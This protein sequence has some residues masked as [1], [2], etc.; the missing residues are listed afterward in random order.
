MSGF[1]LGA[2]NSPNA[3]M[4]SRDPGRVLF[5]G[6][7]PDGRVLGYAVGA[8]SDLA[9]ELDATEPHSTEGVFL[10]ITRLAL[11]SHVEPL[12][13][14]LMHLRTIHGK[15]WINGQRMRSDGT[16]RPYIAPN[17]GG[18]TLEAELGIIPNGRAEP[19]F[20]GW[21]I[22]QYSVNNL[23][24]NKAKLPVTLMTPEPTFGLYAHSFSDFMMRHGYK[25]KLGRE[26]RRN[27]GGTYRAHG[28]FHKDTNIR[29]TI[30]GYNDTKNIIDDIDGYIALTDQAG[31]IAAGWSFKNILN[32]WNRKHAQAVYVPS[33]TQRALPSYQMRRPPTSYHY[34]NKIEIARGTDFFKFLQILHKGSIYIDPG[35]KQLPTFSKKRNP[36]RVKHSDLA[37]LYHHFSVV[38]ITA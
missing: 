15:G 12:D 14:L 38:D 23:V 26:E 29:L 6:I 31:E 3:L 19:D 20:L 37:D 34:G 35:V 21:E 7:C 28:P 1:L 27:F 33:I 13:V 10:S 9:T 30:V 16:S 22:K 5:L 32:H 36:F 25:D 17:G 24:D 11:A 18:Y 8:H 2:R 4:T